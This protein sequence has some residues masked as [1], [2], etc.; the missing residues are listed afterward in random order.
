MWSI[1][2]GGSSRI[3][4]SVWSSATQTCRTSRRCGPRALFS[5]PQG[6]AVAAVDLQNR[7]VLSAYAPV[8]SLDWH[9]IRP[10]ADRRSLCADLYF[11][12]AVGSLLVAAL[13][14]AFSVGILL[15]RRMIVP[16]RTLQEGAARIG[17]GDLRQRISIKTGDELQEFGEQFN[18]MATPP[19]GVIL[20]ARAQGPAAHAPA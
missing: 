2:R 20:D 19:A 5:R 3:P 14:I 6:Q 1:P 16:V 10:I 7:P 15:A 12:Q 13:M 18:Q 9:G 17:G 4:T 11:G 8:P